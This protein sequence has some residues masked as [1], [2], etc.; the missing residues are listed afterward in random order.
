[1]GS[2]Q[3]GEDFLDKRWPEARA[4]SDPGEQLFE[5]FGLGRGSVGQL[6][7][8]SVVWEGMKAFAQGHGIGRPVGNPLRMSGWFLVDEGAV[9]WRHVHEHAGA[10]RRYD[11]L[12]AACDALGEPAA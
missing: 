2:A 1:M 12:R 11:E 9:V 8:P 10:P 7:G 5:A 3:D 6:F 4:V